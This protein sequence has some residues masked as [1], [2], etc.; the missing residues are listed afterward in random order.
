MTMMDTHFRST[1]LRFGLLL[2]L[3]LSCPALAGDDLLQVKQDFSTDPG[4]EGTNNR[5]VA[6]GD[7]PTIKQDFGWRPTDHAGSGR[8][9]EIGGVVWRSRTPAWY[10]MKLRPRTLNDKS[11]PRVRSC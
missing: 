8:P 2:A 5:V 4:W 7:G 9:G 6:E 10:G 11:P 3:S 1:P